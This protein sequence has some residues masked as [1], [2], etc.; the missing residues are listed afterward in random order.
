MSEIDDIMLNKK[1]EDNITTI[2]F[3]NNYGD[4]I[5]QLMFEII[6]DTAKIYNVFLYPE[7]RRK[8]ILK[9]HFPTII[10]MIKDNYI[11]IIE[12]SV[13]SN[14]AKNAWARLGFTEIADNRY[15]YEINKP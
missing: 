10:S 9:S 11:R 14:D 1:T 3:I 7:Y 4:K 12:L 6:G 8:N 15:E 2:E 13:L 5:G